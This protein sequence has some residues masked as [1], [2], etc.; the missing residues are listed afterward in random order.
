MLRRIL[1]LSMAAA[2][3]AALLLPAAAAGSWHITGVEVGK[4]KN[5]KL[6]N[7]IWVHGSFPKVKEK[8]H[9]FVNGRPAGKAQD[10]FNLKR[11]HPAGRYLKA[12]AHNTVTV[13]FKGG[14]SASYRFFFDPG[15][16][17]PGK[18]QKF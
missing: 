11:V 8:P 10:F 6:R 17:K 18:R 13:R 5:G 16:I 12:K 9:W 14:A 1:V 7:S 3:L 4:W 2:L 15:R